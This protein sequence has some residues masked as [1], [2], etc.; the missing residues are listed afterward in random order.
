MFKEYIRDFSFHRFR[1]ELEEFTKNSPLCVWCVKLVFFPYIFL[2]QLS[3]NWGMTLDEWTVR[4]YDDTVAFC[5][6]LSGERFT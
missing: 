4:V 2:R 3:G 1:G 6:F 5:R